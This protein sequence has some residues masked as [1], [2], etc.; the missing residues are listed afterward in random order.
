MRMIITDRCKVW[1]I[2]DNNTYALVKFSSSRKVNENNSWDKIQIENGGAKNGYISENR[3]FVRFVG[4]A[5]NKLKEIEIGDVIVNISTDNNREP[6]WNSETQSFE[7]PLHERITVFDFEIYN[8]EKN[9]FSDKNLDKAP[10]IMDNATPKVVTTQY[11]QD[12][13]V[14]T[15]TTVQY[16][17]VQ[18]KQEPVEYK[19]ASDECPF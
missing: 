12:A 11:I 1:E 17:Q 14:Q 15:S 7:Y 10:Q 2:K 19:K 18:Y 16:K 9:N 3:N 8:K 13:P 6:F 5:Y 4:H